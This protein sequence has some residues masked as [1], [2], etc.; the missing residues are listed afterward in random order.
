[1]CVGRGEE[2]SLYR[3]SGRTAQRMDERG[4]H[5]SS[6]I[7]QLGRI[8]CVSD[9]H[10]TTM[11]S[12]QCVMSS[13][14]PSVCYQWRDSGTCKFGDACKFGHFHGKQQ[15]PASHAQQQQHQQDLADAMSSLSFQSHLIPIVNPAYDDEEEEGEGT[16]SPIQPLAAP[17]VVPPQFQQQ[18]QK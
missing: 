18:Q 17:S 9:G 10:S 8:S 5:R 14:L 7:Q 15:K 4:R 1:M 3:A 6:D 13:R 11:S 12:N 16:M 2:V